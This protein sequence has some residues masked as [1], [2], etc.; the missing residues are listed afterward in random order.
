MRR[1]VKC[2]ICARRY[3]ASKKQPGYRFHCRCGEALEVQTAKSHTAEVVCCSACGGPREKG[4]KQCIFCHSDFTIHD[5]DVD[6]VCPNC[7]ARVSDRAKFCC[8]CGSSMSAEDV[9]GSKTEF[10]CP[11]CGD[12]S[13]LVSRKLSENGVN[14]QE[15]PFCA[16]LWMGHQVF[17]QLRDRV[18]GKS[19]Q[20]REVFHVSAK[21]K[22]GKRPDGPRY[23]HCVD[24]GKMMNQQTYGRGSGVIIDICRKHGIWFDADELHE[25]VQWISKGGRTD[26]EFAEKRKKSISK[27]PIFGPR[28]QPGDSMIGQSSFGDGTFG[29]FNQSSSHQPDLI[30][31][32]AVEV[33]GG[34]A[35][36]F[37][38]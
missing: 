3:D 38:N 34:L 32:L 14:V 2:H 27:E 23:R 30:T 21:M 16:G 6:T 12:K 36:L 18:R 19:T 24:C 20:P 31:T 11:V 15:C 1:I 35:G 8:Q 25:I 9:A 28:S 13:K 17:T 22:R 26:K 4:A 37:K 10:N 5:R 33:L 7:F 29:L